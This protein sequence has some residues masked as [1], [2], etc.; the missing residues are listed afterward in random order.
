MQNDE[1]LIVQNYLRETF[2]NGEIQIRKSD[3]DTNLCN[4]FINNISVGNIFRD[5]DPDDD[6]ISYSLNIPISLSSDNEMTHNQY[7]IKLFNNNNIIL[8]GRGSIGDSQEVYLNQGDE[9]EY[10]GIIYKDDS[11]SYTFTMSILDFDL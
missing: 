7:L 10:I 2:S 8:S 1:I 6:E 3:S 5:E 4:I 11:A 9:K